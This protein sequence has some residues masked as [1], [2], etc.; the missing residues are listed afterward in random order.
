MGFLSPSDNQQLLFSRFSLLSLLLK[1]TKQIPHLKT[2]ILHSMPALGLS[3][4]S[5]PKS[6]IL[7]FSLC[8][9]RFSSS[10]DL[11]NSPNRLIRFVLSATHSTLHAIEYRLS[12]A[13]GHL[14]L[15]GDIFR[16]GQCCIIV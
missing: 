5:L 16:C 11:A 9:F 15:A 3:I 6:T 14:A 10:I 2:P 12:A 1:Y 13:G 4:L 7:H 8:T